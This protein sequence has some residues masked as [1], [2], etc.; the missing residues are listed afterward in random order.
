MTP[1]P[2]SNGLAFEAKIAADAERRLWLAREL[3]DAVGNPLSEILLEMECLKR[4][5]RESLLCDE[6]ELLQGSTRDVLQSLRRVLSGLRDEPAHVIGFADTVRL[7]LE[8][9]ERRSGIQTAL[10]ADD[11]WPCQMVGRT[12][13][14]LLRI[15]D[16]ALQ[17]VRRHSGA[18]SVKVTLERSGNDALLTIQDNGGGLQC[19][20]DGQGYGL[21][22][23][24]E[25]AI[26]A[27]CDL[28]I[29]SFPDQGTSVKV[30]LPL[31]TI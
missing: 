6:I 2:D 7:T 26:L 19:V 8:Q 9:F 14:H 1:D 31:E 21:R 23:M 15:I 22:G 17:N 12:A 4:R 13:H 10:M 16:E 5:E 18:G 3:H 11:T 25:F 24:R 29:E 27:G 30:L 20:P 28:R